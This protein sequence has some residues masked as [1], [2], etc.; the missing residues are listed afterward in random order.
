MIE[1]SS[2]DLPLYSYNHVV[3]F[4]E[5]ARALKGASATIDSVLFVTP[6]YDRSIPDGLKTPLI[7]QSVR[8]GTKFFM[9]TALVWIGISPGAIGTAVAQQS[10]PGV[11]SFCNDLSGPVAFFCPAI[12]AISRGR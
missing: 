3:D 5:P 12:G 10:L 9:A 1:I 6:D 7:G 8:H 2:K 4:P 11:L